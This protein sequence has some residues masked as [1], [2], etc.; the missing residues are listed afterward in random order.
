L[1]EKDFPSVSRHCNRELC[2]LI[3][4][5]F[6]VVQIWN[7]FLSAYFVLVSRKVSG[8]IGSNADGGPQRARVRIPNKCFFSIETWNL[9]IDFWFFGKIWRFLLACLKEWISVKG[10]KV[11]KILRLTRIRAQST[12]RFFDKPKTDNVKK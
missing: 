2:Q 5:P 6:S 9:L 11:L 1:N 10:E 12:I 4:Q 8:S 3:F 7:F